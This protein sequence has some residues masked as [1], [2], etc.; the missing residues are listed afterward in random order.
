[1]WS[2]DYFTGSTAVSTRIEADTERRILS[3]LN[4][5]STDE[6]ERVCFPPDESGEQQNPF[7]FEAAANYNQLLFHVSFWWTPRSMKACKK[8]ITST[9][10]PS[11]MCSRV[12]FRSKM[13]THTVYYQNS[14]KSLQT[15]TV[16]L[17]FNIKN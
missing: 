2:K 4:L 5:I 17:V 3:L 6:E 16:W 15:E 9:I 12:T 10:N 13:P 8:Y 1:M 11:T 7:L 14:V